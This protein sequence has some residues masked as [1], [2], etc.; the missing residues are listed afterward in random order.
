MA[1]GEVLELKVR[2]SPS[3]REQ[4]CEAGRHPERAVRR[5]A[6]R[7]FDF[8]HQHRPGFPIYLVLSWSCDPE[9]QALLPWQNRVSTEGLWLLR[10]R[11]AAP[12]CWR[13]LAFV[14]WR[15]WPPARVQCSCGSVVL[16]H[17]LG[18]GGA[19]FSPFHR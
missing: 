10:R 13:G 11:P 14:G 12:S 2:G 3:G 8:G 9:E 5:W 18:V 6:A 7:G 15:A 1:G 17:A 16:I 19:S 4:V